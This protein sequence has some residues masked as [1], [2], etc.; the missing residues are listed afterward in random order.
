MED[1]PNLD[2][3]YVESQKKLYTGVFYKRFIEGL[4]VNASG[5]IYGDAW[6]DWTVYDDASRP[7]S[8][9]GTGG[10]AD[11]LIGVDYGTTNPCVFLDAIDDGRTLWIDR[12]YYWDSA[13]EYRQ[14]TDSEYADDLVKFIA[15]SNCKSAPKIVVDPSAASFKV[16]LSQR[17]LMV[18]D[19]DNE[20]L[21]GIR[22]TASA[23]KQSKIRV[24]AR[25]ANTR[26]ECPSYAWNVKKSKNGD[27]QPV[28][29]ADHSCDSLRY[30]A[31]QVFVMWRLAA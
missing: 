31:K 2:P 3:E 10:Y 1:N 11:H 19:A 12:E 22:V 14:K 6:G 9:Y 7:V 20:V 30:I 15:E 24:H 8:L 5:A 23:F 28:K 25:C 13:K 4:W 26:R 17:G 16:E 21:D 18:I 29:S 27:E